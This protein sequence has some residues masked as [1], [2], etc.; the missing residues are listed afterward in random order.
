MADQLL[1]NNQDIPVL[2]INRVQ[3]SNAVGRK[4]CKVS[5]QLFCQCQ[6]GDKQ[7]FINFVQVENLKERVIIGADVLNQ[8]M[9]HINFTDKTM[10]WSIQDEPRVIPFAERTREADKDNDRMA[11]INIME[12][13]MASIPMNPV[14]NETFN[15]LINE[16]QEIFSDSPGLIHEHECQIKITPG[17][18]IC[19]KPHPIPI[20]TEPDGHRDTTHD[21]SRYN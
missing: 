4:I 19:Q 11:H 16:Y 14:E 12:N 2:P 9:V 6:I 13:T 3:I 10:Q 21:E 15:Q 20:T 8:Y 1:K 18:H 7:T 5:K 17:E